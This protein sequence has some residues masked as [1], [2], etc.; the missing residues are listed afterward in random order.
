MSQQQRG[1]GRPAD[2]ERRAETTRAILG[3]ALDVFTERSFSEARMGD[4]AS[5]AGVAKGTLYLYFASKEALFE[6]VLRELIELPH[7]EPAGPAAGEAVGAFVLRAL[8][9]TFT[10]FEQSVRGRVLRLVLIEGRRFPALADMYYR[11]VVAPTLQRIQALAALAAERGE[12]RLEALQEF[13]MLMLAPGV[14]SIAWNALFSDG[15][16]IELVD[17]M[18]AYVRLLFRLPD[19]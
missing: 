1:R 6:G 8:G 12:L 10:D 4:I 9:D 15:R 2:P 5:R 16:K 19:A 7:G 3:A 17:L 13:P 11:I 14:L 18:A